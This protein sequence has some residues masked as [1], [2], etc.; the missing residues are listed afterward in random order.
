M[1]R[2]AVVHDIA[3]LV[4]LPVLCSI[5]LAGLCGVIDPTVFA[6][7]IFAYVAL[8][9]IWIMVQPDAVPSAVT[10]IRAHHGVTLLLCIFPLVRKET[11]V[12]ACLD[13]LTEIN[14]FFL[15]ARRQWK[16]KVRH[17]KRYICL[18]LSVS[19]FI[20]RHYHQLAFHC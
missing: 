3:N 12:F 15:I 2:A 10:M 6:W 1:K 5:A 20:G 14:T 13:G 17:T 19:C 7:C 16:A 8:D 11:A 9:T 4:C 18:Y